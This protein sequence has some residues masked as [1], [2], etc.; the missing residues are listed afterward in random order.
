MES[1]VGVPDTHVI[2]HTSKI[3]GAELTSPYEEQNAALL[4]A[5]NRVRVNST[6]ER[7]A[8]CP[9]RCLQGLFKIAKG[10]KV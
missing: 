2:S 9:A 5:V 3:R 6:T 10:E 4:L 7:K 8:I 1:T